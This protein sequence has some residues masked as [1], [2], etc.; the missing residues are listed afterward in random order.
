MAKPTFRGGGIR[1][2]DLG[3][4]MLSFPVLR[5]IYRLGSQP[6]NRL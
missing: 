6:L 1:V 4:L 2:V 5:L 3:E